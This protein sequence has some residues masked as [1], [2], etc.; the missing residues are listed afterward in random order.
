T[1]NPRDWE[2][3]LF[4]L[5]HHRS[6]PSIFEYTSDQSNPF[7]QLVRYIRFFLKITPEFEQEVCG[8]RELHNSFRDA[9]D[10]TRKRYLHD[11]NL[12]RYNNQGSTFVERC[13][14]FRRSVVL[15]LLKQD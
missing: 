9:V 13:Q 1:P 12:I 4:A 10:A 14:N 15:A 2:N 3:L 5:S 11:P 7:L 6:H 8:S